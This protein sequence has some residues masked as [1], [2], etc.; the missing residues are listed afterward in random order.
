MATIYI[1]DPNGDKKSF[2]VEMCIRKK[3]E[4]IHLVRVPSADQGFWEDISQRA[5]KGEGAEVEVEIDWERRVDQV[6]PL[7]HFGNEG[8]ADFR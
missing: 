4:S 6:S 1:S 7:V 5:E 2:R 3:L 8:R